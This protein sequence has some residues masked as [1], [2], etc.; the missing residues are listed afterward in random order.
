TTE[1]PLKSMRRRLR[2][3]ARAA[4]TAPAPAAA[5]SMSLVVVRMP[6]MHAMPRPARGSA[7]PTSSR[8]GA[9]QWGARARSLAITLAPRYYDRDAVA[10]RV[11]HR[12]PPRV[13][14]VHLPGLRARALGDRG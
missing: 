10:G 1:R 2:A 11:P 5:A 8:V 4:A 9:P 6:A 13:S 12:L 3:R 7:L 14:G